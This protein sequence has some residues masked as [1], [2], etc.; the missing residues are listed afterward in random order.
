MKQNKQM[1]LI[2]ITCLIILSSIYNPQLNNNQKNDILESKSNSFNENPYD[3]S[4]KL[5]SDSIFD[6]EIVWS[7]PL[8]IT[9][10]I[11]TR[12]EYRIEQS[13]DGTF[14]CI[15]IKKL[16]LYGFGFFYMY[17]QNFSSSNWSQPKQL[18]QIN[19]EILEFD[20]LID[21]N[22]TIHIGYITKRETVWQINYISKKDNVTSLEK[23]ELIERSYS[24]EFSNLNLILKENIFQIFWLSKDRNIEGINLDSAIIFIA[25]DLNNNLWTEKKIIYDGIN[26]TSFSASKL[27]NNNLALIITKWDNLFVGN[28]IY[29]SC[30]EDNGETWNNYTL[31]CEYDMEINNIITFASNTSG[32]LHIIWNSNE[33]YVSLSYLEIYSNGSIRSDMVQINNIG[34][35]GYLVGLYENNTSGDLWIFFEEYYMGIYNLKNQKR[36]NASLTWQVPSILLSKTKS[37]IASFNTYENNTL[38]GKFFYKDYDIILSCDFYNN[39]SILNENSVLQ[40]TSDNN[41]GSR[42]VDSNKT[43]HYI[44]QYN[45]IYDNKIFYLSKSI[46]E[47]FVIHGCITDSSITDAVKPKIVIDSSDTIHCFFIADDIM[48]G[49]DGLYYTYKLVSQLNWSKAVLVKTPENY[50]QSTNFEVKIDNDDTIHLIW[51]ETKGLYQNRLYYSYKKENE[52][53]FTSIILHDNDFYISSI[54]PSLV[55]DSYGT[56]HFVYIKTNWEDGI[57]YIQYQYKLINQNWSTELTLT[58]STQYLLLQTKLVVD[59][60]DTLWMVYLRKYINGPYLVSDTVLLEKKYN[61][62]WQQN[63]TLYTSEVINYHDFFITEN[64]TLV[65]L[66]QSNNILFDNIPDGP[67]DL[68]MVNYKLKNYDWNGREQIAINL[69]YNH[70]PIGYFDKYSKNIFCIVYNKVGPRTNIH[71]INRQNDFDG[72]ELG[73]E[74]EIIFGSN[75]TLTDSDMDNIMDGSEVN[76]YQTDPALNDTDWDGLNDGEEIFNY[77]SN[78]LLID[79]DEDKLLD[80]EE[81]NIWSTNPSID[82]T[83][84]DSINDYDEIYLYGT[85]PTKEDSESDGMPDYW[86]IINGLNPIIDDSYLDFDADE[87]Y[88]IEEFWNNT[89]PRIDDTDSDGLLDGEEVKIYFTNPLNVD[90]DEDSITDADEVLIF[91]ANPL[92]EDSDQDGFTDREE[93]NAGTNP[94]D[95]KDNVRR[96]KIQKIVL[97]SVIPIVLLSSCYGFLEIRYRI[98]IKNLLVKENEEQKFENG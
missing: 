5:N 78:P 60:M 64:D 44:W 9:T 91:G 59:S 45:S 1:F 80:G 35:E 65:Y 2:I 6:D 3:I 71:I 83:D 95:P 28:D 76:Y 4:I 90:T 30:S 68:V 33:F 24:N 51:G 67:N 87:L 14:H 96:N 19:A 15:F 50:A 7:E 62:V 32:G 74:D 13:S 61:N 97:V 16:N 70:K 12:G 72:D 92:L 36:L 66:Q 47:T 17:L 43:I 40:M 77:F 89:N 54:Y 94:N 48:S 85:D 42:C 22:E 41:E 79:T 86:E 38:I 81:V 57:N 21:Y 56:L 98:R 52:V 75:P 10:P 55:I 31:I 18:I 37:L 25:K 53:Q 8:Q 93:I 63:A 49:Y 39:G 58:A 20:I 84:E 27:K 73:D 11:L 69:K 23:K 26:P 46:D 82:D 34:S 29:F 88:N